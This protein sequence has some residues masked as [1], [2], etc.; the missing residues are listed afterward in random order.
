M[1]F[2]YF[3]LCRN[4]LYLTA[5][6]AGVMLGCALKL[7]KRNIT[8]GARNR[9]VAAI[10]CVF[11][12]IFVCF[13]LIL[14]R[15]RGTLDFVPPLLPFLGGTVLLFVLAVSFPRGA[16]FP[17][18]LFGGLVIVWTGYSF[19]RFPRIR[20]EGA[21]LISMSRNG[22]GAFALRLIAPGKDERRGWTYAFNA[23]EEEPFPEL[24]GLLISFDDAYPLIGGDRRGMITEIRRDGTAPFFP[25]GWL[26]PRWYTSLSSDNLPLGISVQ[27]FRKELQPSSPSPGTSITLLFD[28]TAF[29]RES[30]R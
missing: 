19:L 30:P 7:L 18:V 13:S 4:L 10:F 29:I 22:E 8:T 24:R 21:P 27:R 15:S 3:P 26:L 6:L 2:E 20:P 1:T 16:A 14:I 28:G 17:L 9:I 25:E 12:G 23:G 11:S 5:A